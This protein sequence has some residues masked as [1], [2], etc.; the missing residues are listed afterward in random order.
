MGMSEVIESTN[1]LFHVLLTVV[2]AFIVIAILRVY[3]LYR[4]MKIN[5]SVMTPMLFAGLFTALSGITELTESYIGDLGGTAH[6]TA[7]LLTAIFFAYGI[8]AYQQ[9]LK[10]ATKLH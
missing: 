1:L 4:T 2:G 8:Y 10:K 9:M 6:A 5:R 3:K 7:M